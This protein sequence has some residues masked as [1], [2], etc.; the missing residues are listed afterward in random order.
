MQ[1]DSNDRKPQVAAKE[2][3]IYEQRSNEF[4]SLNTFFWQIPLIMMTLNGGLWF[5]VATLEVD[6]IVQSCMLWFAA[7]ANFVM[8]AALWRL[9]DVMGELLAGIRE[10]EGRPAPQADRIILWLFCGVFFV[11]GAGAFV[12]GFAP[13]THFLKAANAAKAL[14][15]ASQPPQA[16]PTAPARVVGS[17]PVPAPAP[18]PSLAQV[19]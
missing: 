6:P 11:A 19:K 9:R 3:L 4:R 17:A 14:K 15:T 13:S 2:D 8:I 18:N 5:S 12:A 10:Y 7:A 16:A 1:T